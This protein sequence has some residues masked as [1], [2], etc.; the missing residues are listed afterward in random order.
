MSQ[1]NFWS[2]FESAVRTTASA[3]TFEAAK[4]QHPVF[5]S[6]TSVE[7]A[8]A[9]VSPKDE[10]HREAVLVA[11]LSQHQTAPAPVWSA[12]LALAMRPTLI[13]LMRSFRALGDDADAAVLS[14]F[15]ESASRVRSMRRI[16]LRLYSETRRRTLREHRASTRETVSIADI[17]V[18]SLPA[19][20]ANS[21]EEH[22]DQARF[23]RRALTVPVKEGETVGAYVVR[24]RPPRRWVE[25]WHIRNSLS[26]H[27]R[28]ELTGLFETVQS[29]A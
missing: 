9:S 27:R 18:A 10:D 24:M 17:D 19:V 3:R 26:K 22:I 25:R 5:A 11:L 23:V 29:V 15:F 4:A 6:F 1:T 7:A 12:A 16:A 2:G 8:V 20:E 21:M 28:D 14:A 13:S